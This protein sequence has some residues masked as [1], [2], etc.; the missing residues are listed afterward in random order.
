MSAVEAAVAVPEP[1]LEIIEGDSPMLLIAPHGGRAGKAA[2]ATLHPKVNDLHTAEI[3]RELAARLHAS[4]L[5]NS[6]MDRNL[7]D[8][9]RI[10][11]LAERAPWLLEILA[12]R[13][14]ALVERFG[15]A[16]VLLVHGWNIIEPRVDFGLGVRTYG[17]ELRPTGSARVSASDNFINGPL[18][19]LAAKLRAAGITPTFGL[20]YPAGGIHNLVQAF[21]E[22]HRESPPSP[23]SRISAIAARGVVDAA[24]LELSVSV[25]L[26]GALRQRCVEAITETFSGPPQAAAPSDSHLSIVRTPLASRGASATAPVRVGMEFYDAAS[27]I[28][29]MAS[30]DLGT[31]G[32]GARIMMLLGERR[33]ILCTCEGT[34]KREHDR[35]SLG[36]LSLAIRGSSLVLEF[37]GAAVVVP[38]GSTY[39]SIERALATGILDPRARVT[40]EVPLS[41]DGPDPSVLFGP[42][43]IEGAARDIA[44]VFSIATGEA[45]LEGRHYSLQASTRAGVSFTGLGPQK[46]NERRMIWA[47]VH[48]EDQAQDAIELR[49]ID[50]DGETEQQT[51]RLFS[52]GN[53]STLTL[54]SL[55]IEAGAPES[56][57]HRLEASV[58]AS[59][60]DSFNLLGTPIAFVPLSRPGLN[61]SRIY[62]S[63]G[64]GTFQ[65]GTRSA[66]GM[67]EYSRRVDPASAN[68]GDGGDSDSD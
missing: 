52:D 39:L 50:G 28:G 24:Q 12:Q 26:P 20:R 16:T 18:L 35:L 27:G 37:A 6:A 22:R 48:G 7:I 2:Q 42:G 51:A 49:R 47:L 46:F 61:G 53:W 21:T 63:L 29:A 17:R 30:F 60:G 54:T 44:P 9:N 65:W 66:S 23:L 15:R 13:L 64:F 5:I 62:T 40:V 34:T 10:P 57:P 19:S 58:A 45:T 55:A 36:P 8:C 4:A 11:Q 59:A 32:F 68:D 25:R 41:G 38:D 67:F 56:M 43:A 33:V 14:A 3:T 1:W 31:P